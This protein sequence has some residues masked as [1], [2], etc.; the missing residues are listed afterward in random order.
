MTI[1]CH[2]DPQW[3]PAVG[4]GVDGTVG[5]G[6]GAESLGPEKVDDQESTGEEGQRADDP[7]WE[8][9]PEMGSGQLQLIA[10]KGVS[11]PQAISRRPKEHVDEGQEGNPSE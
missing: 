2:P 5:T 8:G 9:G 4:R 11:H 7:T 6:I 3:R 1:V 10:G